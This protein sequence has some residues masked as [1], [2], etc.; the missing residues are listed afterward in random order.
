MTTVVG[1]GTGGD[2]RIVA[3][4]GVV[5]IV[6]AVGDVPSVSSI[7][8]EHDV[9]SVGD[10]VILARSVVV[11][12]VCIST[13][14]DGVG[15]DLQ[16]VARAQVGGQVN[17]VGRPTG[18]GARQGRT[19]V[20]G[21]KRHA[22]VGVDTNG[23]ASGRKSVNL[24]STVVG[25]N[26][27]GCVLDDD[28]SER[29]AR[30]LDPNRRSGLTGVDDAGRV[31]AGRATINLHRC[32]IVSRCRGAEDGRRVHHVQRSTVADVEGRFGGSIPS[33]VSQVGVVQR[34]RTAVLDVEVQT[35]G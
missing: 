24:R 27:D 34:Q 5:A 11:A 25:L 14:I 1:V 23:V 32:H 7:V 29:S 3:T 13:S 26:T 18:R 31:N 12:W 20:D 17:L 21:W 9:H 15:T 6:P 10:E 30:V 33:D 28:V 16:V 19:A 22:T 4:V 35:V 2:G 8:L